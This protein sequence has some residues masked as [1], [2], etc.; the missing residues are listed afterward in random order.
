MSRWRAPRERRSSMAKD[1]GPPPPEQL[2]QLLAERFAAPSI[3]T[4][5]KID[6]VRFVRETGQ[7][8]LPPAERLRLLARHVEDRCTSVDDQ[9]GGW[10]ALARIYDQARQLASKPTEEVEVLRSRALAAYHCQNGHDETPGDVSPVA[11]RIR[12]AAYEAVHAALSIDDSRADLHELLGSIVYADP[13]GDTND[14]LSAF[15]AALAYDAA[16]LYAR[17]FSALALQDLE[18]WSDALA[19]YD[20]V[21]SSFF[22]PKA[23]RWRR[24][25]FL[26]NRAFCALKAGEIER[27]EREM[28]ALLDRYEKNLDLARDAPLVSLVQAA[29]GPFYESLGARVRR[30][31][32]NVEDRTL[33]KM[34]DE[35]RPISNRGRPA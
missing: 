27:A 21:P 14:A 3:Q 17:F 5:A 26:E 7:V 22:D 4:I 31:C 6:L 24:E 25:V 15:E 11:S 35:L 23:R 9:P 29:T 10:V 34:F 1:G 18:R 32:V 12:R 8:E 30:L 19:A 16:N 20:A 33:V 28:T 2:S 13:D